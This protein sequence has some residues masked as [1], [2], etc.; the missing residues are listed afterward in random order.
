MGLLDE[1]EEE[2]EEEKNLAVKKDMNLDKLLQRFGV[3]LD[4]NPM[5]I[6]APVKALW[7]EDYVLSNRVIEEFTLNLPQYK[8]HKGFSNAGFIISE[9]IQRSYNNDFNNFILHNTSCA[10]SGLDQ[11]RITQ[12]AAYMIHG[13]KENPIKVTIKGDSGMWVGCKSKYLDL[14]FDDDIE[15]CVDSWGFEWTKSIGAWIENSKIAFN[16]RSSNGCMAMARDS[17]IIFHE[18]PGK[19]NASEVVNCDVYIYPE[20]DYL[21][22]SH[23][24]NSRFYSPH[25]KTL[26]MMRTEPGK[27]CSFYLLDDKGNAKPYGLKTR[28]WS[29]FGNRK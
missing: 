27:G 9:M 6:D 29:L 13:T 20:M 23:S 26:E 25:K 15:E 12:C 5:R 11:D 10:E 17:T 8:E 19:G 4:D 16:K 1:L 7:L 18:K 3:W 21:C 22:G 14:V 2:I 28:L 24:T